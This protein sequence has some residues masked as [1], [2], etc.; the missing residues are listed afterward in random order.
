[1]IVTVTFRSRCSD[2]DPDLDLDGDAGGIFGDGD[3]GIP[4][5]TPRFFMMDQSQSLRLQQWH[6]ESSEVEKRNQSNR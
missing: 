6:L 5:A 2:S 4:E 3:N 1:V